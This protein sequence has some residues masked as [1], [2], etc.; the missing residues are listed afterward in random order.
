MDGNNASRI[1]SAMRSFSGTGIA[2]ATRSNSAMADCLGLSWFILPPI[3]SPYQGSINCR[4]IFVHFL[5]LTKLAKLH[6]LEVIENEECP[7]ADEPTSVVLEHL[8]QI[9][10]L[11]DGITGDVRGLNGRMD[12]MERHLSGFDTSDIEIARLKLRVKRI[13][14]RLDSPDG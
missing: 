3:G 14:D 11:L 6:T 4:I 13:E 7:M 5:F 12:A 1:S 2:P 8:R 10:S 9:R